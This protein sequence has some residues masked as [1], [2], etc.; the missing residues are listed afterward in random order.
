[1]G[2]NCE[3]NLNILPITLSVPI[4]RGNSNLT[5]V[6]I[7]II[8]SKFMAVKLIFSLNN[9]QRYAGFLIYE[10]NHSIQV[11]WKTEMKALIIYPNNYYYFPIFSSPFTHVHF[12]GF[13]L[14]TIIYFN[15]SGHFSI[16]LVLLLMD[17][18]PCDC[19]LFI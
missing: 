15:C 18:I 19:V 4:N 6:Q 17:N 11:V 5:S 7:V 1:M 2:L 10:S 12:K 8:N 13:N 3:S 16:L 14:L 9:G